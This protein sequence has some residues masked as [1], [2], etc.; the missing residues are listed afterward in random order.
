MLCDDVKRVVYFF[1]D[2]TLGD[3]KKLDVDKH[4]HLCPDCEARTKISR[5]L[6]NFFQK[7][8]ARVVATSRF[9]QRLERTLRAVTTD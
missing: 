2:D 5:R 9:R 1:L 8:L 3:Q 6:R 7:R 4:L